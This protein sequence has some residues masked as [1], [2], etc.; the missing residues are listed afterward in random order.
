[1]YLLDAVG[2]RPIM[3]GGMVL[4]SA[5]MFIIGGL[6]TITNPSKVK[7]ADGGIVACVVL[8][9]FGYSIGW[10]AGN[11]VTVSEISDQKLRD[12]NQA[13]AGSLNAATTLTLP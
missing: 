13:R 12:K 5:M 8:F 3:M 7:A 1:M 2:R 6:G 10:A 11:W 9:A 4:Q